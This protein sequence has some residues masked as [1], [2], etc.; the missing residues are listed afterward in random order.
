MTDPRADALPPLPIH[1]ALDVRRLEPEAPTPFDLAPDEAAAA[2]LA[3]LFGVDRLVNPR[4]AGAVS[5]DGRRRWRLDAR[6]T[7]TVEQRC[8]VTLDPVVTEIDAEVARRFSPDAARDGVISLAPAGEDDE[9]L[10]DLLGDEIDLAAIL[11][12]ELA[13]AIDPYPRAAGAELGEAQQAPPGSA[14]LDPE[15]E[16]PFAKLAALRERMAKDGE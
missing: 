6:L 5:P 7:A 9:D 16:K 13:L 8:V 15:A 10:P 3:R 14:P 2:G 12:E 1:A 4:L 11:V